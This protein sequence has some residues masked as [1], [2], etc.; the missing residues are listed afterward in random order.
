MYLCRG[1]SAID[2]KYQH[3]IPEGMDFF[4][5]NGEL[6]LLPGNWKKNTYFV[7]KNKPSRIV[8]FIPE[9]IRLDV[10]RFRDEPEPIPLWGWDWD[11]QTYENSGRVWILRVCFLLPFRDPMQLYNKL[12]LIVVH[13]NLKQHTCPVSQWNF[14]KWQ[15]NFF[16][17]KL[18]SRGLKVQVLV[19]YMQIKTHQI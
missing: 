11:H 8:G 7:G 10:R 18:R 15:G 17:A 16:Q 19:T 14:Q 5:S 2:P 1:L 3:D 4:S 13:K 9:E 6:G 12:L